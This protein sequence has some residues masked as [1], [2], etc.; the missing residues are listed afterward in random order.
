MIESKNKD[1]KAIEKQYEYV[2]NFMDRIHD[3]ERVNLGIIYII[4]VSQI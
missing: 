2:I 1:K 3:E 4:E